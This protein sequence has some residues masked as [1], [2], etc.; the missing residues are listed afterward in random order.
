MRSHLFG[1]PRITGTR[2]GVDLILRN[3]S[4]GAI[5]QS[6]LEGYPDISE[7]DIRAALAHAARAALTA[8]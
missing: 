8:R 3:L 5:I 7:A 4:E 1:K 6:L 2:I